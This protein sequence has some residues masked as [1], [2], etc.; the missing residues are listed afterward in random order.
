MAVVTVTHKM[1]IHF[2]TP[3]LITYEFRKTSSF[4]SHFELK[5]KDEKQ[6]K[7]FLVRQNRHQ[8]GSAKTTQNKIVCLKVTSA[9][10]LFLP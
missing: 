4:I 3:Y 9:S 1:K 7:L 5:G 2:V 8:K 6:I 10:K